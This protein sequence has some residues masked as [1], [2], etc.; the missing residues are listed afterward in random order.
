MK[1]KRGVYKPTFIDRVMFG[2]MA[3]VCIAAGSY[4][5]GPWYLD[6]NNGDNAPLISLFIDSQVLF[7]YGIAVVVVGFALIYACVGRSTN[8]MYTTITSIA[9]L[10][11]FLLRLYSLIG[12]MITL[13]TW[14]PPSYIT[15]IAFVLVM[16]SYWLWVS[17]NARPSR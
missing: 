5:A 12:V 11:G 2:I 6:K 14:R 15:Q 9:L 3:A 1:K 10:T 13:E 8:R 7:A 16:G 17:F 4:A